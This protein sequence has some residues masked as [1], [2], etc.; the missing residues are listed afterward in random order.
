[1]IVNNNNPF[2]SIGIKICSR[3]QE[4]I[5]TT[6]ALQLSL[7]LLLKTGFV[8]TS[9]IDNSQKNVSLFLQLENEKPQ[10]ISF[11]PVVSDETV[12]AKT[13]ENLSLTERYIMLG[14]AGTNL[15]AGWIYRMLLFKNIWQNDVRRPINLLTGIPVPNTTSIQSMTLAKDS[16]GFGPTK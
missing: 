2:L 12:R 8:D 16:N 14:T 10:F 9:R 1:M 3:N 4:N 13:L 7:L 5:R 11:G 6:A 15:M